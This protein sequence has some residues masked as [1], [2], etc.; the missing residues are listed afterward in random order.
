MPSKSED[1]YVCL[2]YLKYLYGMCSS[3]EQGKLSIEAKG[4]GFRVDDDDDDEI[5]Q[6]KVM[7]ELLRAEFISDKNVRF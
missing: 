6:V 4:K 2:F 1:R 5:R 3:M 7:F